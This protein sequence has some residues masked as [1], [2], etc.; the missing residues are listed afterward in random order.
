ME[1]MYQAQ[2]L[3]CQKGKNPMAEYI[4]IKD[5]S[6]T[7]GKI[8]VPDEV[9]GLPVKEIGNKAFLSCKQV[10]Q[11]LLPESLETLGDWAF[12]HAQN[13]QSI[14]LFPRP[15]RLGKDVFLGCSRLKQIE[16][17]GKRAEYGVMMLAAVTVL[18]APWLFSPER[19]GE[20]NWLLA[21]D[22]SLCLF[23]D[24]DD[25]DGFTPLCAGGEEDYDGEE[26]DPLFYAHK[27][28][29]K[30]AGLC[31]FRLLFSLGLNPERKRRLQDYIAAHTKGRKEEEAW[32][33]FVKEYAKKPEYWPVFLEAGG[34]E[35]A[36]AG[37]IL[38]ALQ[39]SHVELKAYLLREW[40]KRRR[41][42]DF[43]EKMT[44]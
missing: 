36:N 14:S 43:F 32:E 37:Q 35:E 3:S 1:E 6:G 21:W 13:L 17:Y 7:S 38:E 8:I 34:M 44:W 4:I 11:I 42:G 41:T 16:I 18:K 22:E 29:M 27:K 24:S 39:D 28:R 26:N 9:K 5:A 30:K 15:V 25:K 19:A 12:A 10:T 31:C 23:L 20:N 40:Q 33:S 2:G